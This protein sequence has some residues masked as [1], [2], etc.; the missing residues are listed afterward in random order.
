MTDMSSDGNY[1]SV[2]NTTNEYI[3]TGAGLQ[4]AMFPQQVISMGPTMI[5]HMLSPMPHIMS[6]L[7]GTSTGKPG[8]IT[9]QDAEKNVKNIVKE[10]LKD[11]I[12]A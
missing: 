9:D 8:N 3:S 2:R 6:S 7:I 12:Q 5:S 1:P 4:I 11:E 10:A